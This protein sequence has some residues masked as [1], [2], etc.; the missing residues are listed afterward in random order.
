MPDGVVSGMEILFGT[1]GRNT[2]AAAGELPAKTWVEGAMGHAKE[3]ER[4]M[5]GSVVFMARALLKKLRAPMLRRTQVEW[6][7]RSTGA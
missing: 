1:V 4:A 5:V 6:I 3:M 2:A 7:A